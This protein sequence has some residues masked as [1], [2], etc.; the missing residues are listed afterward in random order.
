MQ[1][2]TERT[3]NLTAA[4]QHGEAL[5]I[6]GENKGRRGGLTDNHVRRGSVGFFVLGI[7]G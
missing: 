2:N 6:H 4:V 7:I 5:S 1:R 3:K